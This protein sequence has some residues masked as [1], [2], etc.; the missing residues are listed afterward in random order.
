MIL[1]PWTVSLTS[2][3][4]YNLF[5]AYLNRRQA[6]KLRDL[7][8]PEAAN[9]FEKL[10]KIDAEEYKQN[11]QYSSEKIA[12]NSAKSLVL[13]V[14]EVIFYYFG[15][16]RA[17]DAFSRSISEM[18]ILRI[19]VFLAIKQLVDLVMSIPFSYYAQFNIEER[20]GFNKMT[21][22]LFIKDAVISFGLELVISAIILTGVVKIIEFTGSKML[23]YV[24]GFLT[25]C[26]LALMLIWPNFIAPLF[27]KFES[28][29]SNGEE[30]E[31]DLR[32]RVEDISSRAKFP[33]AEIY[34]MDGSKRSAHSQAYFFGIFK[35][36]RIVIYDTLIK[37]LENR[38]TE[39]VLC[40]EI[41]HWFHYHNVQMLCAT[42]LSLQAMV[43]VISCFVFDPAFYA[44]FGFDKIDYFVGV[45]LSLVM[46]SMIS[47]LIGILMVRLSRRNE[48]QAD[49]FALGFEHGD[50]LIE[51]LVLIY[52]KNKADLDPDWL[53][54]SMKHTHPTL[55]QRIDNIVAHM[56][57]GE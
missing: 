25:F 37:D 53:Y 38:Q 48:F 1:D 46:F 41:G 49:Q 4:L 24:S 15:P 13:L 56:K 40:H 27:N 35:K 20:F 30:K 12:L 29:G 45:N 26:I 18:L 17:L 14:V 55:I 32:K 22:G 10:W 52:K 23:I 8:I 39:A 3:V 11:K 16:F 31:V 44:S 28:L 5:D 34:K 7:T 50:N 36:K 42:L 43:Y 54:S 57:K 2:V 6:A 47:G 51:A 19:L 21:R 9:K 33:V